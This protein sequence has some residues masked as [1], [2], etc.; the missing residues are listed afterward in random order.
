[1]HPVDPDAVVAGA[2]EVAQVGVFFD[3]RVDFRF[4]YLGGGNGAYIAVGIHIAQGDIRTAEVVEEIARRFYIAGVFGDRPAVVPDVAAFE[5]DFIAQL[6]S[7]RFGFFYGPDGVAAPGEVEPCLVLGHHLLTEVGFPSGDVGLHAF[8]VVLGDGNGFGGVVVHQ[9][10]DRDGAVGQFL[11]MGVDDGCAVSVAV[12]VFHQDLVLVL[13]IP[14]AIPGHYFVLCDK[15]LVVEQAGCS[16]HVRDYVVGRLHAGLAQ[17]VELLADIG[18]YVVEVV[19][20]LAE[21]AVDGEQQLLLQHTLD[22]VFGRAYQVEILVATL[23][24]GEHDLV[25]VE[26]LVDDTDVFA[27]LLL[28][29]DGELVEYSFVDIVGPVVYLQYLAAFLVRAC[30]GREHSQAGGQYTYYFN[31]SIHS[32]ILLL[33]SGFFGTLVNHDQEHQYGDE[34]N[35]R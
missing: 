26:Y 1:M 9:L 8:Q 24:L 21:V 20:C 12:A 6:Y 13:G 18:G 7:Y 33:C 35:G 22:D 10:F 32:S 17:F 2:E 5:G 31:Q 30:T 28:I 14:E 27:G 11:G 4:Q 3:R 23:D 16:P 15:L 25:D 19:R 34:D 29:P